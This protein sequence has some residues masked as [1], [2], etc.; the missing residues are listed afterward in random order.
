MDEKTPLASADSSPPQYRE[1]AP[2]TRIVHCPPRRLHWGRKLA[3]GVGHVF[4]DLAASMWFT[5]LILF[6][7]KV[8][9]LDNALAG[10][11]LLIGQLVDGLAT[12]I[13]GYLCDITPFWFFGFGRRKLWHLFGTILVAVSLFFFWHRCLIC[14]A[15]GG[16]PLGAQI[17]WYAVFI[18]IFQLGWASV[19]IS[20][21]SL[22]PE[23]TNEE[24]ERVGLNAIRLE[25]TS[26]SFYACIILYMHCIHTLLA[27][28]CTSFYM[29]M[30]IL[31]RKMYK[32]MV[33]ECAVHSGETT[34]RVH[35]Q[36]S[37]TPQIV[38]FFTHAR[39]RKQL[40][41]GRFQCL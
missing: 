14:E 15:T 39:M 12:P 35:V 21:L 25:C 31:D 36:K 27:S 20:H 29:F 22:I 17:V 1:Y 7:H 38:G 16:A 26:V 10:T 33:Y 9:Q 5:Y 6:Y 19:Q 23:L 8:I 4:N 24:S 32:L 28:T 30:H 3:Y 13:I 34:W 2:D 40:I 18:A 41:P 37:N 11:L